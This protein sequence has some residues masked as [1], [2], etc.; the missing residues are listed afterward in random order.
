MHHCD[1][2]F[3]DRVDLDGSPNIKEL[4]LSSTAWDATHLLNTSL[5]CGWWKPRYFCVCLNLKKLTHATSV[6]F[7]TKKENWSEDRLACFIV[8]QISPS[9]VRPADTHRQTCLRSLLPVWFVRPFEMV[10][11]CGTRQLCL[12]ESHS[13]AHKDK[14]RGIITYNH[15]RVW[16]HLCAIPFHFR[17]LPVSGYRSTANAHYLKLSRNNSKGR[18]QF[19]LRQ[20]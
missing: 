11:V 4:L 15:K 17:S 19:I 9:P 14:G 7:V 5:W 16:W 13:C 2:C 18:L 8:T 10:Y 12:P 6:G 1:I 3:H 20:V